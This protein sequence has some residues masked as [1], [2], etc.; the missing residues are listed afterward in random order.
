[1]TGMVHVRKV[2]IMCFADCWQNYHAIVIT[3]SK[4]T[5]FLLSVAYKIF[6]YLRSTKSHRLII[7]VPAVSSLEVRN[8]AIDTISEI[9]IPNLKFQIQRQKSFKIQS[10][11]RVINVGMVI[12]SS[13]LSI[14]LLMIHILN[15]PSTVF[16]L[17]SK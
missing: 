6:P 15:F 12:R 14:W 1:M 9:K 13:V 10:N 11:V 5:L 8:R 3:S 7:S 17:T 2:L 4:V 16:E